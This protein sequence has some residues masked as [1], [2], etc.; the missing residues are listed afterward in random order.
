MIDPRIDYLK[1]YRLCRLGF[2]LLA[3]GLIPACF[4]EICWFV[5]MLGDLRFLFFWIERSGLARLVATLTPW[6]TL[7][8]ASVLWGVWDVRSWHRRAGLLMTMCLVD[9]ACW[10]LDQGDPQMHGEHAWFRLQLG[11][12]LGWAEFALLASLSGDMLAH[13]GVEQA[14]ESANSTRSLA[15]TGAVVWL[16]LFCE[17]ADLQGG[18]PLQR[19]PRVSP[20]AQLL[21]MGKELIQ[22]ICLIQVTALVVAAVR[23]LNG[24]LRRI[25]DEEQVAPDGSGQNLAGAADPFAG[26]EFQADA[27]AS[28]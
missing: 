25:A 18:W 2:F 11:A 15:A 28:R 14:E 1:T 4:L 27:R 9:V 12:A 3:A 13:L 10:F 22:T 19:N 7:A 23:R 17:T 16:L 21:W 20:S 6:A 26:P 8:G 5:G 24:E